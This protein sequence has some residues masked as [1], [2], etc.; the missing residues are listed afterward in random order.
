[1]LFQTLDDKDDC[2]GIYYQNQLLFD[3]EAFPADLGFTWKYAPYLRDKNI[4]YASLYLEGSPLSPV[5]PE[6]LQDDWEDISKKLTAFKRSLSIAQVDMLQNCFFDLVPQRFLVEFC[7]I[8]NKITQYVLDKVEKPRRYNFY[9]HT[10]MM[11][12]DIAARP[13]AIDYR[14]VKSYLGHPKLGGY[15]RALLSCKP[16]V[17]YNQFGTKTGRLTTKKGCFPILTLSKDLRGVV[18]PQNDFFVELDFNGAE[19]RTLLGLLNSPQ[20]ESDVHEFHLENIFTT[21]STRAEAKV[22]FFAWLYGS[23]SATSL[24]ENKSLELFYKKDQLLETY[25]HEGTITTP[26]GKK[27]KDVS[28]HHALNYLIQ[29]T[30]AELAIKQALKLDHLLR[31]KGT[32]SHLAFIIHDA[33][34]LDMKHEDVGLLPALIYLMGST[35]YGHYPV[36]TKVGLTLGGLEKK[37]Y[38]IWTR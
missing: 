34:V 32:G 3:A 35:N 24:R 20:P 13:V 37:E 22:A 23:A 6:Y 16:C 4:E 18:S 26:Y 11:L 25:W 12:G 7:E 29:S 36:N 17:E 19:V 9:Q 5:L 2:V 14:K 15:A 21:L 8:K 28:R 10:A 30:S 27:I 1:M 33:V 31:S 38:E